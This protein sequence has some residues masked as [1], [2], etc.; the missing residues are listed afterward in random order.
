MNVT[1]Y[2]FQSPYPQPVQFGQPDPVAKAQEQ[3]QESS[4]EFS[5]A[6]TPTQQEAEGF[7]GSITASA[8]PS[9]NVAASTSDSGVSSALSDFSTANAQVQAASAYA[10]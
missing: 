3:M 9:V 5:S 4:Q 1:S 8:A 6:P 10:S 7:L 2:V